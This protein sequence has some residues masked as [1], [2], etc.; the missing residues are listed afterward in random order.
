MDLTGRVAI[1]TGGASNIGRGV[2]EV[3]ASHGAQVIVA[4]L[5]PKR[6]ESVADEIRGNGCVSASLT[7]DV[8]N[9]SSTDEMAR[10]AIDE[11][12]Q[13]D[14]LVNAA[15]VVGGSGWFDRQS[16]T[17]ADWDAAFAVNVRGIV[18]A[19]QSVESH[20]KNRRTGKIVNVI[21]GTAGATVL[22]QEN[23]S[24][25]SASRA[26]AINVTQSYA[27]LLGAFNINVNGIC[28]GVIWSPPP[29]GQ[30]RTSQK[31]DVIGASSQQRDQFLKWVNEKAPLRREQIPQDVG[32]LAVF[33]CSDR[34]RNIT[35]QA[36]QIN[37]GSPAS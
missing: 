7:V 12:G 32:K 15:S 13:V 4:D 8:S 37:G 28:P 36:I 24:N 5:E 14:I 22:N 25:Y 34:A 26:S 20:M 23:F 21:S 30:A 27:V 17:L 29:V 2:A 31:R 1:V 16:P 9:S 19:T 33:L 6:A 18:H 10:W 3:V 11:F 35:G